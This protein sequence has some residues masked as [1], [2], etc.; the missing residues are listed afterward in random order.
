MQEESSTYTSAVT[1]IEACVASLVLITTDDMP[2]EVKNEDHIL[3]IIAA[4]KSHLLLNVLAVHSARIQQLHRSS[5]GLLLSR[6]HCWSVALLL[7]TRES[8][9]S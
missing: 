5:N 4:I 7:I 6:C 3:N 2:K 9:V 8:S 1:C